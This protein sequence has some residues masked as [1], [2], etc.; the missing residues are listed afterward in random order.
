MN[1]RRN[2]DQ[3][4][5]GRRDYDK[6]FESMCLHCD[7]RQEVKTKVSWKLF[8]AIIGGILA[9]VGTFLGIGSTAAVNGAERMIDTSKATLEAIHKVS[10]RTA[11]IEARQE[12]LMR[13]VSDLD[14]Q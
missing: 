1:D 11:R 6:S 5:F 7:L 12:I 10:E 4:G 13:R 9:I 2:Y 3:N 14:E 8:I